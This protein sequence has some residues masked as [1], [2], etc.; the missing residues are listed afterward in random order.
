MKQKNK[1]SMFL[2]STNGEIPYFPTIT[3][4]IFNVVV[5]K[6]LATKGCLKWPLL[7]KSAMVNQLYFNGLKVVI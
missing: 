4:R 3:Q 5:F 1:Q 2:L 6:V 7:F